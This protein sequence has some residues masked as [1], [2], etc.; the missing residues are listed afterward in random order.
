MKKRNT[1]EL[2]S[3]LDERHYRDIEPAND[4]GLRPSAQ[5]IKALTLERISAGRKEKTHMKKFR[6]ALLA[7][8][9]AAVLG[10]T[11]LAMGGM[12]YFKSIFGDSVEQVAGDVTMPGVTA[13]RADGYTIT[14]EAVL[15]D[16]YQTNIVFSTA[17]PKGQK[18]HDNELINR[19]DTDGR[20]FSI[21]MD[22]D[23]MSSS[24]EELSE[25]NTGN[26]RYFNVTLSTLQSNKGKTVT[27][28]RLDGGPELSIP[29]DG[30]TASKTVEL[31]QDMGGG[32][33]IETLQLSP[34]GILLISNEETAE[35]GLPTVQVALQM[36]DG[37]SEDATVEFDGSP[38]GEAVRGGGS[39]V[40]VGPDDK[41]PLVVMTHA[42][43]NPD[44]KMI[45]IGSFSRL[46]DL[47]QVKSVV[48]AGT[49]YQLP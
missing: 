39:V 9:L 20:G 17:Y 16:G 4:T 22:G 47:S 12:E 18:N 35:G 14:A 43:R 42:Q 3:L 21:V 23:G 49:E 5:R 40:I 37:G 44:G 10:V 15:T 31:N 29:L 7:A 38:D 13:Q 27:I 24:I 33:T 19:E 1:R 34:M 25:F 6:F 48:V 45:A 46:V 2:V 30:A 26:R 41:T 8:A 36:K 28:T 11:A 32:R